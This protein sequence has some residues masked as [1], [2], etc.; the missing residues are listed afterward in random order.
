MMK[1]YDSFAL[2]AFKML[3]IFHAAIKTPDIA[4]SL[5]YK[6]GAYLA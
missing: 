2:Y 1:I 6:S 3:V 4:R 5:N